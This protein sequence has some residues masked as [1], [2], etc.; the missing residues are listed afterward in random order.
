[1][2]NPKKYRIN[3]SFSPKNLSQ[4]LLGHY[5][6]KSFEWDEA[7][8]IAPESITGRG[9]GRGKAPRLR[10][11]TW[12][13]IIP[14]RVQSGAASGS[15]NVDYIQR[16]KTGFAVSA[17]GFV[18]YH[19]MNTFYEISVPYYQRKQDYIKFLI[20]RYSNQY[21][22]DMAAESAKVFLASIEGSWGRR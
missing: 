1:M 15:I 17:F 9:L 4:E 3:W 6:R 5:R 2:A 14:W 11:R 16:R 21:L 8:A 7:A 10:A 20:A 18:A 13:S 22:S 12:M 19:D